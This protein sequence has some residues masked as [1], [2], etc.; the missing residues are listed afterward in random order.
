MC[1]GVRVGCVGACSGAQRVWRTAGE[2]RVRAWVS[3]LR[4]CVTFCVCVW[5]GWWQAMVLERFDEALRC[6]SAD[7]PS[8]VRG[9]AGGARRRGGHTTTRRELDAEV[10]ARALRHC[11]RGRLLRM[12]VGVVLVRRRHCARMSGALTLSHSPRVSRRRSA[13][14]RDASPRWL[15]KDSIRP[16]RSLVA[17]AV[18]RSARARKSV[19]WRPTEFFFLSFFRRTDRRVWCGL[20]VGWLARVSGV[21]IHF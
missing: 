8:S 19:A 12:T 16:I 4:G 10:R 15:K 3:L 2:G 5:S 7:S 11:A 20:G 21:S 18:V 14:A 1:G 17:A 6:A 13:A 9:G